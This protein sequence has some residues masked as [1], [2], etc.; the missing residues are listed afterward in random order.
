MT[1]SNQF[2]TLPAFLASVFDFSRGEQ[3]VFRGQGEDFPLLP[4]IARK[5]P[6]VD[7]SEKEAFV[8]D[9]LRRLGEIDFKMP[10]TGWGL[11]TYAQHYG[12]PTRLLDWSHNPLV[13]VWFAIQA[14]QRERCDSAHVY[15]LRCA[16]ELVLT[17]FSNRDIHAIEQVWIVNPAINNDRIQAQA[18]CFTAHPYSR[19]DK[20]Y[21][22]VAED[23]MCATNLIKTSFPAHVFDGI[24]RELDTLGINSKHIYADFGG[25]CSYLGWR[26]LV[27]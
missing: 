23:S 11:T 15:L 7:L 2:E 8:L 24:V 14:A 4:S 17:D 21:L 19:R 26:H 10:S 20:K 16:P 22:A 3:V 9:E 1:G 25:L 6:Q 13:S 12:M 27:A 18:G 5:A